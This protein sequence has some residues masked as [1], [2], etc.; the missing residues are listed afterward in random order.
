MD[1]SDI[2]Y[3]FCSGR[4]KWESEAAGGGGVDFFEI[5]RRGGEVS[6]GGGGAEG[7]GRVCSELGNLG[8]GQGGQNF[9]FRS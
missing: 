2:F 5:P 3:F 9:L 6:P 7:P 8:G 4:G 1:V